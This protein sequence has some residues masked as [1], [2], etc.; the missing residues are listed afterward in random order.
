MKQGVF[1]Q[2]HILLGKKKQKT[3]GNSSIVEIFPPLPRF[4]LGVRNPPSRV[5]LKLIDFDH[6]FGTLGA[7]GVCI[8]S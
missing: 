2:P 3:H 5:A 6:L 1:S 4:D 7:K 8:F